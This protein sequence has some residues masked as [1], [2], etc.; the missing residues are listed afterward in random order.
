MA[1]IMIDLSAQL[2]QFPGKLAVSRSRLMNGDLLLDYIYLPRTSELPWTAWSEKHH[3]L[4]TI[5]SNKKV[6]NKIVGNDRS[7][8][9][10]GGLRIRKGVLYDGEIPSPPVVSGG[11]LILI[12][13]IWGK[14]D[15]LF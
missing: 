11:D 1:L 4:S 5:I 14:T 8:D 12:V 15:R 13:S 6:G 10:V 2:S 3:D 9:F 7:D